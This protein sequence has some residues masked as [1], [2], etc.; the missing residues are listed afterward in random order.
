[1]GFWNFRRRTGGRDGSDVAQSMP[2]ARPVAAASE[3]VAAFLAGRL[4]DYYAATEQEV[5]AWAALNRLAHADRTELAGLVADRGPG[6]GATSAAAVE[7][8]IAARLL[9]QARTPDELRR[10]Q[11]AALVPL[12][13]RL[14]DRWKPERL[15]PDE[16]LDEAVDALG[17]F[18]A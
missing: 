14:V 13:L 1:M 6:G 17:T 4:V 18:P 8:L 12:E 16:V 2:A 10:L 7:L 11:Q 9:V 15:G 5:P 3:E